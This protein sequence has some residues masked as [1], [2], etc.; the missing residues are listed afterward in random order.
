[1]TGD[2]HSRACVYTK[3]VRLKAG[4]TKV[5]F[6]RDIRYNSRAFEGVCC[7]VVAT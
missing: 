1:M 6:A 3:N 7:F 4:L 5:G 2:T